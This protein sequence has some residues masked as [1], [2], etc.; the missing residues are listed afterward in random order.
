MKKRTFDHIR[1]IIKNRLNED[2][3]TNS[4]SG[5]KIAGTPQSGDIPP[6]DLRKN[7]YKKLPEF[8]RDLFRRTRRV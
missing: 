1:S 5:G 3:P 4:L 6:V 8:Y 2:V 7:R